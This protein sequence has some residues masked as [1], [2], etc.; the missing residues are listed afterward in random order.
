MQTE[1]DAISYLHFQRA[2]YEQ[3][4]QDNE[5]EYDMQHK[6]SKICCVQVLNNKM[7]STGVM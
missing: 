4:L 1:S 7:S 5:Y 6:S 3:S 2:Q